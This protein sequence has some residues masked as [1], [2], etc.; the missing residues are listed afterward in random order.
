M[1]VN[2]ESWRKRKKVIHIN[3]NTKIS[4]PICGRKYDRCEMDYTLDCHGIPFR[5]VCLGCYEEIMYS[6]PGYDGCYYSDLEE[7]L[8][9]CY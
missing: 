8:D 5:L 6:E 1:T 3:E 9:E 7:C 2:I 4:C